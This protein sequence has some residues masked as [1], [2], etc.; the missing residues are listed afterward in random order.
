MWSPP[1]AGENEFRTLENTIYLVEIAWRTIQDS[2]RQQQQVPPSSKQGSLEKISKTSVGNV[3][4]WDQ[5]GQNECAE[6]VLIVKCPFPGSKVR[7]GGPDRFQSTLQKS[8]VKTLFENVRC[9]KVHNPYRPPGGVGG[10]SRTLLILGSVSRTLLIKHPMSA[11]LQSTDL[12]EQF[13]MPYA[14]SERSRG[15]PKQLC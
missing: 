15:V 1:Q 8:G 12:Q 6:G 11:T 2:L 7:N 3:K 5:I 14:C 4:F 10:W 13:P 9:K